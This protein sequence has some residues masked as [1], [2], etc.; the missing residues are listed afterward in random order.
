MGITYRPQS[1][2]EL[3]EL[4]TGDD[5]TI[6][7]GGTDLM[8]R[9]KTHSGIIPK[10][11]KDIVFIGQMEELKGIW[12]E[13]ETLYIGAATSLSEVMKNNRVDE[14]LRLAINNMSSP[15]IRNIGT[16]G[17][18]ICNASPAGDVL[19]PLFSLDASLVLESTNGKREIPIEEFIVGPSR[20]LCSG[21]EILKYIKIPIRKVDGIYY[22]KIG[23]RRANAISKLSIATIKVFEGDYLKK[24][25]ISLG[26]VAP[27]I[28]RVREIENHIMGKSRTEIRNMAREIAF[29]YEKYINPIDDIRSTAKYRKRVAINLICDSLT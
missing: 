7:A 29:S 1:V 5:L 23:A 13:N 25:A 17:G 2:K 24:V 20:T 14:V 10:F 11:Q 18:N 26:A 6:F 19:P 28:V 4:V 15:A 9:N 21:K 12:E 22:K 16:I 8:V 3:I 27:K